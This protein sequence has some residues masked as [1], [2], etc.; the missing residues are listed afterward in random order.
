MF[1]S[2]LLVSR[3]GAPGSGLSS[4]AGGEAHSG[5]RVSLC[6]GERRHRCGRRSSSAWAKN[7]DALRRISFA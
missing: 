6:I 7:A 4:T 3:L 1:S 5:A 2:S